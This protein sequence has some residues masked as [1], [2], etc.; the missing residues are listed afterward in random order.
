MKQQDAEDFKGVLLF[1]D[2]MSYMKNPNDYDDHCLGILIGVIVTIYLFCMVLYPTF[3]N[4]TVTGTWQEVQKVWD[5]WQ[6]LNAA[7][8]ALLASLI[9]FKATTYQYHQERENN[10]RAAKA[11]LPQALSDLATYTKECASVHSL[12]HALAK[13]RAPREEL[14]KAASVPER[15]SEAIDIFVECI[16]YSDSHIGNYLAKILEELQ[17]MHARL[18][19]KSKDTFMVLPV[20]VAEVSCIDYIA[21]SRLKINHLFDFAR[22]E[23]PFTEA[24]SSLE[25]LRKVAIFSFEIRDI[26]IYPEQPQ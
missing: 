1:A 5:R 7:V 4:W 13:R 8:I 26:E 14:L 22:N 3:N 18:E 19:S 12:I 9:A 16:K 10:F 21:R 24:D 6:T 25:K 17:V 15:P 2:T 11:K 23:E 20:L